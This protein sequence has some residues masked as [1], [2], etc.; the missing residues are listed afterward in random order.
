MQK[1]QLHLAEI[2]VKS[3]FY[4]FSSANIISGYFT[5]F[6]VSKYKISII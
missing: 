2:K 3:V 1:K 6:D 4:T 5:E